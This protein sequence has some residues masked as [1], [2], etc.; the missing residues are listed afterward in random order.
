MWRHFTLSILYNGRPFPQNCLFPWGIWTRSNTWFLQPIQLQKPNSIS[1]SSAV[2]AQITAVFLYFT[3]GVGR[4]FRWG[5][6]P[7]SNTWFPGSTRVLN[8]N[9][10]SIGSVTTGLIY[11]RSTVMRPNNTHITS[12]ALFQQLLWVVNLAWHWSLAWQ[13]PSFLEHRY[14]TR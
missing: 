11:V 10:L 8:P 4:P 12:W 2:F 6:W 7:S 1:I 5:S 13:F 14:F 3:M 9:G